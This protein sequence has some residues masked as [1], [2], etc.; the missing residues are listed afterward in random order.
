MYATYQEIKTPAILR[1]LLT[2]NDTRTKRQ[3][4]C[5]EVRKQKSEYQNKS[6]PAKEDDAIWSLFCCLFSL[7]FCHAKKY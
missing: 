1:I 6:A 3:R 5:M 7:R 2:L 4:A